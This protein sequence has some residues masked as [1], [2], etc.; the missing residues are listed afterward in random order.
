[1]TLWA[2]FGEPD[3]PDDGDNFADLFEYWAS[4]YNLV[5]D[6]SEAVDLETQKDCVFEQVGWDR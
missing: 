6:I 5:W 1:M 4:V 2:F 3:E